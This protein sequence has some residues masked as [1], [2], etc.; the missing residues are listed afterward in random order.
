MHRNKQMNT[1]LSACFASIFFFFERIEKC[2]C[3]CVDTCKNKSNRSATIFFLFSCCLLFRFSFSFCTTLHYITK[4]DCFL[5][6]SRIH[7]GVS[8]ILCTK[9]NSRRCAIVQCV[10]PNAAICFI[11]SLENSEFRENI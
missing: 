7:R 5:V 11:F 2:I 8:R 1:V 3:V 6:G 9:D 10:Q 4:S